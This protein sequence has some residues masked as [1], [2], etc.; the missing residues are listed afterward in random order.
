MHILSIMHPN[1]AYMYM[2]PL[3]S[4]HGQWSGLE[5]RLDNNKAERLS[6]RQTAH[7]TFYS[8]ISAHLS[9]DICVHIVIEENSSD[10]NLHCFFV[11]FSPKAYHQNV[12]IFY[13]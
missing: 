8:G 3:H 9:V 10:M 1:K 6:K 4:Q 12:S 11:C 2:R 7:V 13:F 5:A